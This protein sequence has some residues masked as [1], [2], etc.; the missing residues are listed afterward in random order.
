MGLIDTSFKAYLMPLD[1]LP[2]LVREELRSEKSFSTEYCFREDYIDA[3]VQ[4]QLR[5]E[6]NSRIDEER[7]SVLLLGAAIGGTC[8]GLLAFAF[9]TMG[10]GLIV[11]VALGIIVGFGASDWFQHETVRE[12]RKSKMNHLMCSL[13]DSWPIVEKINGVLY[14]REPGKKRDLLKKTRRIAPERYGGIKYALETCEADKRL[15]QQQIKDLM[16]FAN[17]ETAARLMMDPNM[18]GPDLTDQEYEWA[19]EALRKNPEKWKKVEELLKN[20]PWKVKS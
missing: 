1:K 15:T 17:P 19:E 10:I 3:Y 13:K 8:L 5:Q 12:N 20:S 9:G 16:D 18:S 4:R 2:P 14:V 7:S 6:E 11:E